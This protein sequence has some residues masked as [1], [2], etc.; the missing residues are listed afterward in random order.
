MRKRIALN[1]DRTVKTVMPL[2][3]DLDFDWPW[4]PCLYD[5][6]VKRVHEE[7]GLTKFVIGEQ[8][9]HKHNRLEGSP[10]RDAT[11][12]TCCGR[13]VWGKPHGDN[14]RIVHQ[15][16]MAYYTIIFRVMELA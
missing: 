12:C 7:Y 16:A 6:M 3:G 11:V 10:A 4:M 14:V 1:G 9:R 2:T 15:P 8:S 5:H 13:E